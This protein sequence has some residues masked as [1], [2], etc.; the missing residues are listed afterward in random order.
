MRKLTY[1]VAPH[2]TDSDCY[3][4]RA[5]TRRECKARREAAGGDQRDID[6]CYGKPK[7]VT[8]EFEDAFDLLEMCLSEG[9]NWWE[10]RD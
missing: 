4:I 10:Y 3:S 9:R 6:L 5:K 1:W 2:L 8:V 7:K